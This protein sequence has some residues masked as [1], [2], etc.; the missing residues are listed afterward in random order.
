MCH[1]EATKGDGLKCIQ[2]FYGITKEET[3]AIGDHNNDLEL[4][5]SGGVKVA[6]G[7]ATE[8]LK[9]LADF[10]T[11]TV[12]NDGFIKAVEKFVKEGANV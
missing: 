7:N 10:V 5:M 11:D 3:L 9:S 1:R 12:E 4:L 6:M 8:Q 2:D